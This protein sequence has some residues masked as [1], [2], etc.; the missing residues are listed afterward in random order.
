MSYQFYC[1]NGFFI[2]KIK[3]WTHP[4]NNLDPIFVVAFYANKQNFVLYF[5]EI[6]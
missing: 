3:S 2:E 5:K 4:L 1:K 6:I